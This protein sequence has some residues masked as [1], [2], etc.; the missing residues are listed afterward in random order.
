MA[1]GVAVAVTTTII[2]A[3]AMA[4]DLAKAVAF[5]FTGFVATISTLQ[6]N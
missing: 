3:V 5:G 1:V 6:G 4:V 2:D